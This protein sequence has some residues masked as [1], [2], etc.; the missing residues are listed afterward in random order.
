MKK[1]IVDPYIKFNWNPLWISAQ[2]KYENE[3]APSHFA[4]RL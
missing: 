3:Q 4:L 1:F 2:E